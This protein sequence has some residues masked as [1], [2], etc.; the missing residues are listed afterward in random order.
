MAL[1]LDVQQ[2]WH[3]ALVELFD[4][5]LFPITGNAADI[6][7]FTNQTKED[8][9]PIFWQGHEYTALPIISSG[10]EKS[11]TGTIA[12]PTLTVANILGTFSELVDQYDDLVGAKIT[13]HRTLAKYLDGEPEADSLQEF[14]IDVFYIER[15]SEETALTVTWTLASI[16]DL[17]GLKLP[18]RI[19]T[20]NLCLWKYRSSECSYTGAPL[21]DVRDRLLST[22]GA[23]AQ[24]VTL[25]NAYQTAENKYNELQA[26]IATR[27][28]A[29]ERQ[30]DACTGYSLLGTFYDFSGG[31]YVKDNVATISGTQVL[32][33]DVY[34]VG[35]Q[36]AYI[37][38]S[39]YF[40][41]LV[42]GVDF[43]DCTNATNEYNAAV[44]AVNAAQSA[45]NTAVANYQAAF[46][47]LPIDDP[48]WAL[49][50][51][52]KRTDSCKLRF[53]RQALPFGGFPGASLRQS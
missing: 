21:F 6:Y 44:A 45:Y 29:L 52:G 26:A 20:Q 9:S 36:Y 25:I 4:I 23:S 2:G 32:L 22:S 35:D 41:L 14:P 42:Y 28:Q 39:S 38:G 48:L 31:T 27:N 47:A 12:Q 10:Y 24:A 18:R 33:S 19:I 53:P 8:G 16:L 11:T 7:Y 15:K 51:C 30:I 50:I 46:A 43:V 37:E 49:D 3:D 1:E 5:D 40:S 17:E 34:R 13:R